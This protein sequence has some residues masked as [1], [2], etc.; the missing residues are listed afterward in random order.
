MVEKRDNKVIE[1]VQKSLTKYIASG[2]GKLKEDEI[3]DDM[4]K[5]AEGYAQL[6]MD[7]LM[8][9]IWRLNSNRITS[10]L[11]EKN[12]KVMKE[13]IKLLEQDHKKSEQLSQFKNMMS[14][15]VEGIIIA[16][17]VG[18][19]VNQFT[20]LL[21]EIKVGIY[22]AMQ[23]EVWI[24]TIVIIAVCLIVILFI[25]IKRFLDK[26]GELLNKINKDKDLN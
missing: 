26:F 5:D 4:K 23:V 14:L 18:I 1:V 11:E 16:L 12:E 10:E 24:S 15:L 22:N 2:Y 7:D 9:E 20:E 6:I 8:K 19:I 25:M 13:K 3:T 17:V 21:T